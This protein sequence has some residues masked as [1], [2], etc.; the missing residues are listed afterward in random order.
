[1][2][3]L[4]HIVTMATK[5]YC[6]LVAFD[7]HK[8]RDCHFYIQQQYSYGRPPVW[9]VVHD[10]YLYDT[11]PQEYDTYA[12]ALGTLHILVLDACR[13]QANYIYTIAS[14]ETGDLFEEWAGEWY[15][16]NRKLVDKYRSINYV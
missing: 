12:E 4:E 1:M 5:D 3:R 6:T 15:I 7:H 13:S 9:S 2:R 14:E 16:D 11:E 10:G 8:D